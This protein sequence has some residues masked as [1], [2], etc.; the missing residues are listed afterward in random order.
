MSALPT[1]PI[2]TPDQRLR[3]FVSSTL[4][5]LAEERA[6]VKDAIEHIRLTPVMFELGASA[7]PPRDLYR[8]YLA[9]SDVFVGIYWQRYGWIAPGETLSGLEDEYVLA[10]AKPK[11]IYIK[12][13]E[14]REAGLDALIG[15]IQ[16][17]DKVSYRPFRD[18]EELKQL[19]QDDLALML[20]ER[21]T[22]AEGRRS[23]GG[24]EDG[25]T[26][27]PA[28]LPP[29]ERGELIGRADLT[30][31]IADLLAKSDTGCLTLT[32]PGGTGKTR[33]AIHTA[34][35]LAERFPDGVFYVSLASVRSGD[36]VVPA[37]ASALAL[38]APP[39]GGK[40]EK[41]LVAFLRKRRALLVLDN[42]EQVL[43]AA[44]DVGRVLAACPSLKMLVT[45]RE[46]LRIQNER[47]LPVPPL[48]HE[49]A[50]ELFEQRAREIVPGFRIGD[51]N[52][53]AVAEICR[54]LDALPL[55]IELAAARIRV[56]SPHAMLQRLDRSLSLLTSSRRDVPERQ[57]TLRAA[58]EWSFGLLTPD[59]QLFFR[60][61][62]TFGESFPE[63]GAAAVVGDAPLE[64]LEG[65][66]SLVEKS[67]L[68]RVETNGH[69]RFQM[70]GTVR[71]YARERLAEAG[72]EHDARMRHAAWIKELLAEAYAPLNRAAERP[73]ALEQLAREEGNVRAALSFLCGASG[74]REK[75]WELFCH[76]AWVRHLQL[77]S[78]DL[79]VAYDALRAKGE[80][81][82]PVVAAAALGL[83]T[84]A[85]Y[86]TPS[87]ASVADFTRSV[88]VLEAHGERRFLPGILAAYAMALS[89]VDP[90]RAVPAIDRALAV[91]VET[92][93][94]QIEGWV[95]MTRCM[96]FLMGGQPELADRAA[97]ELI[98]TSSRRGEEE[99][100]TFGMTTK[101]RLQLMRG[102]LAAARESFA[103]AAAYARLG[104][105]TLYGRHDALQGLASVALAQGDDVAARGVLEELV[106]FLGKRNGTS[107]GELAWGA[108]A[109]LLARSGEKDRAC[110]VLE[111]I[112]RGVE[113][114]PPALKMQFDPTGALS[115]A[116]VDA[117]AMLGD[118]EPLAPE[119]VDVEVALRAAVGQR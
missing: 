3:I 102:D 118:P 85:S 90:P 7:H 22:S 87:A 114:V 62:G 48:A 100:I 14:T 108:L 42:F 101:G 54:R 53:A 6:A 77:Q 106:L 44:G 37:I 26:A 113:I 65:L 51:D 68:V 17:D 8:A 104:N 34:N 28:Y 12:R 10:S 63:E 19:V 16:K 1:S 20:T 23:G 96:H 56:L 41:L 70:F 78:S 55:A 115:K 111:V 112:P 29:V 9:Q 86:G 116:T 45:S 46:A 119:L 95:R 83:I 82:D 27:P 79:R 80:S 2:R 30:S 33:L 59:E 24:E 88:A 117:R 84:W 81:A 36:E 58:L 67:L 93:C 97:D 52:R 43:D 99:G 103:G 107:G 31:T 57:Q 69:V 74:D 75:A 76:L 64:A 32:G 11:L 49:P 94:A 72:E 98:A 105:S 15:R 66:T 39:A 60:R 13:A 35:A 50:M 73:R 40:H 91:A 89:S 18:A 92:M 25:P 110:R 38:P 47:E 5:E 71:E 61:L 4:Q 21:F 109:C